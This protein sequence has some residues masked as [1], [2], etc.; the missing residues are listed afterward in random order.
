MCVIKFEYE[1]AMLLERV[2]CV[3][4]SISS[5][6]SSSSGDDNIMRVRRA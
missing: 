4:I 1:C 2:E 6:S 5:S 3:L